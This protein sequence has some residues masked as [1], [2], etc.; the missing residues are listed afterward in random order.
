MHKTTIVYVVYNATTA[1]D[2]QSGQQECCLLQVIS[3]HAINSKCSQHNTADNWDSSNEI[4]RR[5]VSRVK[6]RNLHLCCAIRT[7]AKQCVETPLR[8][9]NASNPLQQALVMIRLA[10]VALAANLRM[11][12]L[13][14]TK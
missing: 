1:L 7:L 10:A 13:S 2:F 3:E 9:G 11:S 6:Q 4:G 8:G 14:L 12:Q 5:A